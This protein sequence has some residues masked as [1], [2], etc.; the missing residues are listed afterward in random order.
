[1][2]A[3]LKI[4]QYNSENESEQTFWKLTVCINDENDRN[5]NFTKLLSAKWLI[6]NILCQLQLSQV[7]LQATEALN[8]LSGPYFTIQIIPKGFLINY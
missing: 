6:L 5:K 8:R 7:I 3:V 4:A 2:Y 1:M